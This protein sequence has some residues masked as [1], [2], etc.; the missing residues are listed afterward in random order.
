MRFSIPSDKY[1]AIE[2]VL[3]EARQ[4]R[5]VLED[6]LGRS[7]AVGNFKC[8]YHP[9][10]IPSACIF[11]GVNGNYLFRCNSEK[12]S[13]GG[14][15]FTKDIV[16]LVGN[17]EKK[18]KVDLVNRI[19][20]LMGREDLLIP[21]RTAIL[22]RAN[23]DV[24][25]RNGDV[26]IFQIILTSNYTTKFKWLPKF[27]N[28]L[29]RIASKKIKNADNRFPASIG[30]IAEEIDQYHPQAANKLYLCRLAGLIEIAQIPEAC[31][32]AQERF[33]KSKGVANDT[34]WHYIPEWTEEKIKE[35]LEIL[36]HAKE[37]GINTK[38][39]TRQRVR[40]AFGAVSE[41]RVFHGS[42]TAPRRFTSTLEERGI[43][44]E[45]STRMTDAEVE[46]GFMKIC[47]PIEE[48]APQMTDGEVE[49]EFK[50]LGYPVP[51]EESEE[52][53]WKRI[54]SEIRKRNLELYGLSE[55]I[56]LTEREEKRVAVPEE[57]EDEERTISW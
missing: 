19:L 9:D 21:D 34:S 57:E 56:S 27:L 7:K 11:P 47:N 10:K 37:A 15:P 36:A 24:L 12:C 40:E 16:A 28:S 13:E 48:V 14:E 42:T 50:K 5:G 38:S 33:K 17:K 45:T 25:R 23:L 8:P 30:E 20:E 46:T 22:N 31:R 3:E 4:D 43:A 32:D 55:P 53:K 39:C 54:D 1:Q 6:Y 35:A 41:E 18:R 49:A 29:L 26:D 2:A 44:E 51:A 52:K